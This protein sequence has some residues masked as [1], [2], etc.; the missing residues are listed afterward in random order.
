MEEKARVIEEDIKE[1][2]P[3]EEIEEEIEED[4][5]KEEILENS[6]DEE[7]FIEGSIS[8]L[9]EVNE[10]SQK[11]SSNFILDDLKDLP[12]SKPKK[13]KNKKEEFYS[14]KNVEDFYS[15][16]TSPSDLYAGINPDQ[17][18]MTNDFY[19]QSSLDSFY[20]MDSEGNAFYTIPTELEEE[21]QEDR[22]EAP[23]NL[24]DHLNNKKKDDLMFRS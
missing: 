21:N 8:P 3:E 11:E 14:T 18:P 10:I 16:Q 2:K 9:L 20:N 5:T 19:E 12:I 22:L 4:E 24:E 6:E 17:G 15:N 13:N 23:S 7:T 1:I